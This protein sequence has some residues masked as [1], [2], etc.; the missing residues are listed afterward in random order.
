[1][2]KR[3][4]QLFSESNEDHCPDISIGEAVVTHVG[5]GLK[6]DIVELKL[7]LTSSHLPRFA[8]VP[9]L[10]G[11]EMFAMAKSLFLRLLPQNRRERTRQLSSE[12]SSCHGGLG[13]RAVC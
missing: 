9:L 11:S 3:P 1:M 5:D 6:T 7:H 12:T 13:C 10:T 8:E 4:S 2:D